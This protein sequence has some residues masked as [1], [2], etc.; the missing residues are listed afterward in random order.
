MNTNTKNFLRNKAGLP[1]IIVVLVCLLYTIIALIEVSG[2]PLQFV[3]YDGHYSY[4]IAYRIFGEEQFIS[5]AYPFAAEM[6]VAYRFQRILYPLLARLLA[7]NQPALIPWTLILLNI[8]AIGL[9]TW[10]T[11]LLLKKYGISHWYALI[12]GLFAGNL[13]ALRSN[14]NEPLAQ[15]LIMLAIWAWVSKKHNLAFVWFAFALLAKETALLFIAAYGLH[16]LIQR[17]WRDVIGLGLTIVPYTLYQMFL[18]VWLGEPGFS[19][20]QP[21]IWIPLGG[22]LVTSQTSIE[23]L[24]LISLLIVPIAVIPIMAG[25]VICIRALLRR[26]YH[27][28]VFAILFNAVFMLFLPTLT[29]RESSAMIRVVQG[30]AVSLLLF[31]AL[32]QSRRIL[33]YSVLWL[34]ANVI[35]IS[36]TG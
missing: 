18:W 5:E 26:F 13:V 31:S 35:V 20:G 33:N 22:W 7:A 19:S 27:P 21:F 10:I 8:L 1:T 34:F 29:F 11:E 2:D 25:L 28:Y 6:P 12:Y 9:G 14:M 24:L 4:Q 36:G 3:I 32:T 15:A 23:A 17:N 16:S 30:L